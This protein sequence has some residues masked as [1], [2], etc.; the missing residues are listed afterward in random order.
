[1]ATAA[2]SAMSL[3]E[4]ELAPWHIHKFIVAGMSKRGW[5]TWLS[6]I[7]DDRVQAIAPFVI[8]IPNLVTGLQHICKTYGNN[9]PIALEPYI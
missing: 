6:A 3:A 2:S 9:W 1:M 5:A 4:R 8:D 7:R